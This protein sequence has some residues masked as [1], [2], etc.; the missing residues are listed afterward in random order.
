M[1]SSY[2]FKT[3]FKIDEKL[4]SKGIQ[5]NGISNHTAKGY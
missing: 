4:N 1:S 5:N 2:L 3:N